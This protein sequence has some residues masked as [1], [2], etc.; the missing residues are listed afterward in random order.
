MMMEMDGGAGDDADDET[1]APSKLDEAIASVTQHSIG[2]P[3]CGPE[4]EEPRFK[5]TDDDDPLMASYMEA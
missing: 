3:T 5:K 2:G 4:K 1:Q